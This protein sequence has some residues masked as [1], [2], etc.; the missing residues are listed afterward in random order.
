MTSCILGITISTLST[1]VNIE[2]GRDQ[3][4][5]LAEIVF[6]FYFFVKDLSVNDEAQ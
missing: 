1:R 2:Q 4:S 6:V 5:W 3:H